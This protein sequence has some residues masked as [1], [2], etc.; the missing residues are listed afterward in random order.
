MSID[1]HVHSTFSDGSMS[2]TELVNYA[3]QKGLSALS[4]TDHDTIEGHAEAMVAGEKHGVEIVPG[5]ELSIKCG[6]CPVHMLGYLF[7]PGDDNLNQQ[8][9]RLQNGRLERN[10]VILEN[11]KKLGIPIELVELEEVS[12]H[13]QSGRPHIAQL[14]IGKGVVTSMDEAFN[15]YL[16]RGGSAYAPRLV[17]QAHEAISMIKNAG[18]LAVLAH[19]QQ[20]EKSGKDVSSIIRKLLDLGL[21]G[22]EVYYPTHSRQFKKKLMNISRKLDL[23]VTGGS[24]YHGA[25]RPGT[26]LA[27][28]KNCS[29]SLQIL[30]DLK[31]GLSKRQS[32]AKESITLNVKEISI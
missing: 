13:G 28:G 21:D 5:V 15:R 30:K 19:P 12:G 3:Q 22:I 18:G 24:D 27:G 25:I 29:V 10:K 6:E 32:L 20:I 1:L 9:K 23:L 7:R 26:T 14:L 4:I 2:P 16:A 8:L 17:F 11:L 31:I